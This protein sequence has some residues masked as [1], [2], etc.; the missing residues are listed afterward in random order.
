MRNLTADTFAV[1]NMLIIAALLAL[2]PFVQ[3]R[4]PWALA[5]AGIVAAI[6][7]LNGFGHPAISL[8]LGQYMPGTYTAP[9]LFIFGLLVLRELLRSYSEPGS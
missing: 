1:N 2:A 7:V 8:S 9:L 6:E 3:A 5:C 4:R